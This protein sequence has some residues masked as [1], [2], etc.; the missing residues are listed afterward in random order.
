MRRLRTNYVYLFLIYLS[1]SEI[2]IKQTIGAMDFLV[3]K[4]ITRFIR[5][6]NFSDVEL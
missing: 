6:N 1:R 2:P 4:G 3:E 5:V